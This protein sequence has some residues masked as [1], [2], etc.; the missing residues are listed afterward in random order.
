MPQEAGVMRDHRDQEDA[1]GNLQSLIVLATSAALVW[2][3]SFRLAGEVFLALELAV[4][5]GRVALRML[6]RAE[7]RS[8]ASVG[9][10]EQTSTLVG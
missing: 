8:R 6:K 10:R 4:L 3:G 7:Q 1:E 2:S 5:A 9:E